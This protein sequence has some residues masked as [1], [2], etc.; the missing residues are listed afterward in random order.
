MLKVE[1][2]LN[3]PQKPTIIKSFV[4]W[5]KYFDSDKK[6]K[7]RPTTKQDIKLENNVLIG[8]SPL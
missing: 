1:K 6:T 5:F 4:F 2:V 3:P 7:K 8:K